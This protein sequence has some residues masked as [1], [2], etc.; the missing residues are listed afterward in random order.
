MLTKLNFKSSMFEGIL[1]GGADS[2]FLEESKFDKLMQSV[3]EFAATGAEADTT[4]TFAVSPDELEKKVPEKDRSSNETFSLSE[5]MIPDI[6]QEEEKKEPIFSD[7][8]GD[9]SEKV[10]DERKVTETGKND[11]PEQLISQS[12]NLLGAFLRTLSTPEATAELVD[13]LIETD[14]ETG[15][16][17]LKIPVPGR[18]SVIAGLAAIGKLLYGLSRD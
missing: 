14:H 2:I 15:K 11:S 12:V 7:V 9:V 1:D 13:T 18:D 17:S 8:N 16:T 4:P 5:T 3:Q 10:S 6:E